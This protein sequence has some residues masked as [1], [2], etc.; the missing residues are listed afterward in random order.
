MTTYQQQLDEKIQRFNTLLSP[1]TPPPLTIFRSPEQHYRMRA[2]FRIWHEGEQISYAMFQAGTKASSSSLLRLQNFPTAHQN[3]NQLM[4]VLLEHISGSPILKNKLYQCEF[5]T[6]LSGETL[7]TLIYHRKLDDEWQTVAYNLQQELNIAIIGRSKGQKIVLKQDFVT[8]QLTVHQQPYYYR[9]IEG[10]F[11]QP[12]AIIC[13]HMLEWVCEHAQ[14]YLGDLLELYCGNGN[15]T[16]PLSRH[17]NKVLATEISK[18]SVQAA[19]WNIQANHANNIAL[20][21]LSAEEFSQAFSGSRTFQRLKNQQIDLQNYQ[22]ST[23]FVDPPRAG[24]DEQTLQLMSPF[25]NIIYISCNPNTL[26]QNLA[27][28]TQTHKIEAVALFDQFPFTPHIESGV[29]LKKR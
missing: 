19:Q 22:F 11:S 14:H 16:I 29:I 8:E 6:T 4:P 10:S 13:Q 25:E 24:I 21:R 9:Q 23:I 5:L 27:I 28:L 7:V 26:C 15:F 17:F 3:I 20:A 12:N 1:F 2:E 18:T